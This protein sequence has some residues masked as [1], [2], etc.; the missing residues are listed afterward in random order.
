MKTSKGADT[1]AG[2][3]LDAPQDLTGKFV[4]DRQAIPWWRL[5]PIG[6]PWN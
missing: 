5:N 1:A 4:C 6:I 2:L 3:A